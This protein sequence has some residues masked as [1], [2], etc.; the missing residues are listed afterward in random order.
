VPVI[1]PG[2]SIV[3]FSSNCFHRSGAN[4]TKKPAA[5]YLCQYRRRRS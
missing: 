3:C 4:T 1:V 5:S 2:G